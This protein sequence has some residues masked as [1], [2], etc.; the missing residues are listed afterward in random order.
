MPYQ[1][2]APNPP[3]FGSVSKTTPARA[4]SAENKGPDKCAILVDTRV[5]HSQIPHYGLAYSGS[6]NS[7][8]FNHEQGLESWIVRPRK[9]SFSAMLPRFLRMSSLELLM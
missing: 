6:N 1:L 5:P 9:P 2:K 8:F 3:S 4:S 7:R